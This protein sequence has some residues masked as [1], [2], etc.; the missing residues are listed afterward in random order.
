MSNCLNQLIHKTI[1]L[2]GVEFNKKSPSL[3]RV[4]LNRR[5]SGYVTM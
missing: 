4:E 5:L 2:T 3:I 1:N